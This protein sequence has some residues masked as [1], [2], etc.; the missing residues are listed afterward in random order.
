MKR[1]THAVE[2]KSAD[3][4]CPVYYY[5]EAE[6]RIYAEALRK[7]QPSAFRI[8]VWALNPDKLGDATT[9]VARY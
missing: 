3:F 5:S 7:G 4:S 2:V 9:E 6:A 1:H 8:I